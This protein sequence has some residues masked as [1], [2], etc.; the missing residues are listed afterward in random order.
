MFRRLVLL[1]ALATLL[2]TS[3]LVAQTPPVNTPFV[4]PPAEVTQ[5]VGVTDV[6]V[7]YHRPLVNGRTLWGQV[8]PYG[9][10]WRAGAN[11]N[12]TISFSTDVTIDGQALAAGTYG[13]HML[14]GESE[15]VVIFS[16]NHTSWGSFSYDEG[17]D[18]LRVTVTPADAPMFHEALTYHFLDLGP[19]SMTAALA[20]GDKMVP[21]EVGIDLAS[22]VLVDI[23]NQ[24]RHLAGFGWSG[25][26]AA[27]NYCQQ[28]QGLCPDERVI[29]WADQSIQAERRFENL[30]LKSQLLGESDAEQAATLRSEAL[31]MG[32]PGQ[33]HQ[34]GRQMVIAGDLDQAMTIFEMNAEKHPETWFVEVGLARGHAAQGDFAKAAAHM[35]KAHERA[36]EPQK[37]Y[38]QG[39]V[40]QLEAEQ[41]IG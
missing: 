7:N 32:N 34:A 28:N 38:I 11:D 39:L 4:S 36:P 2:A 35:K 15:W 10:V 37:A 22:T 24:L 13:L 14:P 3:T 17:E 12:T 33:L 29:G 40:D 1:A 6:T 21:F 18:A 26:F 9:Q 31:A 19:T 20:W 16:T 41:P 5:R 30:W 23:E 25:P 27:A 8:V